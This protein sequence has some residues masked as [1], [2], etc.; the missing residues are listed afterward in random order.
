MPTLTF[1]E[2]NGNRHMCAF[3]EGDSILTV[4]RRNRIDMEGACEGA[5]ACSTCHIIVEK[6]WYSLLPKARVEENDMLDLAV[7][8]TRTSRLGCQIRLTN[9]LDGL[10]V[11]IP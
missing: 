1:I 11:R 7:G 2:K 5:M 3:R 8:V 10:T 9:A 4:A 6:E